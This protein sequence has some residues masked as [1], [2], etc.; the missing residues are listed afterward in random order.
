MVINL[1]LI[2]L[3]YFWLHAIYFDYSYFKSF[4]SMA[5]CSNPEINDPLY[6]TI[7]PARFVYTASITICAAGAI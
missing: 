1:Y 6:I 7:C 5:F 3:M 2:L 4:I